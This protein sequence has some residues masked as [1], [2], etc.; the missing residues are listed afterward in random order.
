MTGRILA[1]V[2]ALS[3][4]AAPVAAQDI[5]ADA[6]R[7]A[8]PVANS[9]KMTGENGLFALLGVIGVIVAVFLITEGTDPAPTSP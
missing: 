6:A 8:A 5:A 2:A 7:D 9:E 3:L 1:S 4:A